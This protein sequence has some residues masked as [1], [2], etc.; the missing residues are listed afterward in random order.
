MEEEARL[1]ALEKE[2]GVTREE[3]KQILVDIRTLLMEVNN[4]I[5]S[6]WSMGALVSKVLVGRG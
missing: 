6:E 3:L 1:K 4:P 2:F 5:K